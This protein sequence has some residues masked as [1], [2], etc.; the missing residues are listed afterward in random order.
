MLGDTGK[1]T[2][3]PYFMFSI[4]KINSNHIIGKNKFYFNFLFHLELNFKI[5][6]T[7]EIIQ[8]SCI[9]AF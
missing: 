5:F 8:N 7:L 4:Q 6:E 1:C 9:L 3:F 2:H